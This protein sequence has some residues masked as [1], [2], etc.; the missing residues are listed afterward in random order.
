MFAGFSYSRA[1]AVIMC[2]MRRSKRAFLSAQLFHQLCLTYITGLNFL[3]E[4][5]ILI[6]DD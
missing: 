6:D 2:F 1:R 5:C 3:T 4:G